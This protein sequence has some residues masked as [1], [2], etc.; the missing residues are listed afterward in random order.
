[1]SEVMVS[2]WTISVVV[3]MGQDFPGIHYM[4]DVLTT[5]WI[6]LSDMKDEEWSVSSQIILKF[7]GI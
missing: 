6:K 7:R 3:H 5:K 2:V 4:A 1:M